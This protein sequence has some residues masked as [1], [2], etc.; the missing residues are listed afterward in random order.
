MFKINLSVVKSYEKGNGKI[1]IEGVAS[2]PTIDRDEERF[3]VAAIQKMLAGVNGGNIPIK[4]EHEHKFYSDIGIWK[5]ATLD[6]DNRL[7]VKGEIDTE[8]S[9]GKD[10][11]V[12]L[13]RGSEIGLSVGGAV[14]DAIYEYSKEL[15]RS[16]KVYK[17]VILQEISI[18]KH[19][20]NKS[21]SLS[22]SMA[23]SI[24]WDKMNEFEKNTDKTIPYSTQA[25]KLIE[26]YKDYEKKPSKVTEE[27]VKEMRAKDFTAWYKQIEPQVD[28]VMKDVVIE[29]D[30]CYEPYT[31]GLTVEDLQLVA[32]LITVM[33]SVDLPESDSYPEILTKDEFWDN[34][35]EEQMIVLWNRE[36]VMPHHRK[37]FVLDKELV[38]YQMKKAV[39]FR[40]YYT[41]SDYTVIMSHL[42]R[43]LK[44][45]DLLKKGF[46]TQEQLVEKRKREKIT[47]SKEEI[48]T[49]QKAYEYS[50]GTSNVKPEMEDAQISKCAEAYANLLSS[51]NSY[52]IFN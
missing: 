21:T 13:K 43:H 15:G 7:Y 40:G 35:V 14:I 17:D 8:M 4:C 47:I 23:K 33:S 22:L 25:Q 10:I 38:L 34:L 11:A 49:L 51:P 5:E 36:M 32:Q 31:R 2:D 20:S 18:V 44:D 12:L 46:V 9:L 3:D 50:K 52:Y 39:D 24:D 30:D 6:K 42:F 27:K 37:D 41:P 26:F 16:I 48:D 28:S 19:P 45:L 1:V 29:S